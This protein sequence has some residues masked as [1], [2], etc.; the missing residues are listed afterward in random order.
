V[1]L[2]GGA[3]ERSETVEDARSKLRKLGGVL[4][5]LAENRNG[6]A[7]L[8]EAVESDDRERWNNSL[9]R[10]GIGPLDQATCITLVDTFTIIKKGAPRLVEVCTWVKG[11]AGDGSMVID[12]GQREDAQAAFA[13]AE[14]SKRVIDVLKQLGLITCVQTITYSDEVITGTFSKTL[15]FGQ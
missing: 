4:L 14:T 3:V 13:D 8:L 7:E 1:D 9:T 6:T 15:C 12:P 10:V 5:A 11:E 2:K